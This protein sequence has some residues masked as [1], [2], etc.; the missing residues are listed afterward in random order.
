[1]IRTELERRFG[2][3]ARIDYVNAG[4]P[5]HEES[6]RQMI[7]EISERGLLYPVTVVDGTPVYDGAVS[8]SSILR[9]VE[10]RLAAETPTERV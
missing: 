1:M 3:Q 5:G 9:I 4:D 7:Q 10:G 8:Y 6:R 2:D